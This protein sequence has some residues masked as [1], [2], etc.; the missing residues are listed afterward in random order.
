MLAGAGVELAESTIG[1]AVQAGAP[2]PDVSSIDA[3]KRTL[4]AAK[5]V[6]YSASVSGQYLTTELYQQLGIA[7]EMLPKSVFAGGGIRSGAVCAR[8]DAQLA[9]QQ[10]SELLPI[11]GIDHITPLPDALQRRTLVAAGIAHTT[12]DEGRARKALTFLTSVDAHAEIRAN[13]LTPVSAPL[14]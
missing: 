6:A 8:G 3:F 2:A 12:L 14:P 9:V 4:L 1:I 10:I 5:S 7:D 11:D 13:G